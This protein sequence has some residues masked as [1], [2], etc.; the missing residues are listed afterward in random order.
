LDPATALF[1]NWHT[2]LLFAFLIDL[3]LFLLQLS[4][5]TR[6]NQREIDRARAAK[7]TEKRKPKESQADLTKRKERYRTNFV[8]PLFRFLIETESI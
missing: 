3:C 2:V 6:G 4:I 7:R 1:P 8:H 5:M